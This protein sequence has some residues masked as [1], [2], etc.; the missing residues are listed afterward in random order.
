M[1][2]LIMSPKSTN[3]VFNSTSWTSPDKKIYLFKRLDYKNPTWFCRVKIHKQKGYMI[4][5][6]KTDDFND[7]YV[8]A[9]NLYDECYG[10]VLLGQDL[11]SKIILT[12]LREYIIHVEAT[13]KPNASRKSKLSY[14]KRWTGF[15]GKLRFSEMNSTTIPNLE[16]WT[17]EKSTKEQLAESTIKRFL[18]YLKTFFVWSEA[19]GYLQ[20]IPKF[21]KR[22]KIYGRRPHFNRKDL[23]TL[24]SFLKKRLK[25]GNKRIRYD[26]LNLLC[27]VY[28]LATTGV[29]VG[30]ARYLKWKDIRE[31][32]SDN[33]EEIYVAI[34]V[35]GKT[36]T[37]EVVAMSPNL[38][39]FLTLVMRLNEKRMGKKPSGN[40]YVFCNHDG[41]TIHSFRKSFDAA[42]K[43]A[44]VMFNSYGEKR[45]IYSLRH[46]YATE[47]LNAGVSYSILANNMGT[48]AE[49][50]HRHYGHLDN[51]SSAGELTKKSKFKGV[52]KSSLHRLIS[53]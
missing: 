51:V 7:A 13:E 49:I 6:T 12:A 43:A 4:R 27:Y 20:K 22:T 39:E 5:S 11:K 46:S 2:N 8:F 52:I 35:K 32:L 3:S 14:L 17:R 21:S 38:T 37:R 42:T 19:Q 16:D 47:R 33:S 30:E 29:R 26:R 24:G 44:G 10:K 41:S 18:V 28:L 15:F 31:F 9:K 53:E 1:G 34:M 36:G 50:L 45:T 23:K 48:S 40:D 25:G